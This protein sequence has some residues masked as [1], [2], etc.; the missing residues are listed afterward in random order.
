MK[1]VLR[2]MEGASIRDLSRLGTANF[3]EDPY[4]VI[5]GLFVVIFGTVVSSGWTVTIGG[6]F[7]IHL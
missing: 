7:N 1:I 4:L 5:I 2:Q 6:I 3:L